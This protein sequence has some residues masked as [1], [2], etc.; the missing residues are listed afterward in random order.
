MLTNL[1][2]DD[3]KDYAISHLY[4]EQYTKC[5][6]ICFVRVELTLWLIYSLNNTSME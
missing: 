5:D 3:K 6:N 4:H 1:K 2:S